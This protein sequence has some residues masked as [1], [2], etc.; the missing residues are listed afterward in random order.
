MSEIRDNFIKTLDDS[1]CGIGMI[2]LLL[3]RNSGLE[4]I[5]SL[6]LKIKHMIGCV[7]TR[8]RKQPIIALYFEFENEFKLNNL[9]A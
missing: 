6:K 3:Q 1:Q 2:I 5:K 4:A 8:V 9:K 7:S